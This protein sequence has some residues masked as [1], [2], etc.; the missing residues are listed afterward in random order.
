MI[1]TSPWYEAVTGGFRGVARRW[2]AGVGVPGA[3]WW[4]I[5][6]AASARA[7]AVEEL[8][9]HAQVLGRAAAALLGLLD[10]GVEGAS[11]GG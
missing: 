4:G 9:G 10:E 11:S 1:D 2:A 8:V 3:T 6:S 5:R 7:E